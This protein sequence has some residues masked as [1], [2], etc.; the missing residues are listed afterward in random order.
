MSVKLNDTLWAFRIAFKTVLGMSSYKIIF[1]KAC[2]LPVE[3]EHRALWAIK[4][5]NFDLSKADELRR[6][7]IAELEEIRNE[8]Y[9]MLGSPKAGLNFSMTRS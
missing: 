3:L 5:L 1:K 9:E 7:Q 6:L 2:Y 4:Q 8:A